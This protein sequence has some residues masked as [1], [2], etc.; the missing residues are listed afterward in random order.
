M[1]IDL[2]KYSES[3]L[4]AM[5]DSTPDNSPLYVEI[6][7]ELDRRADSLSRAQARQKTKQEEEKQRVL[8][9]KEVLQQGYGA[10]SID[11]VIA[12]TGEVEFG[13]DYEIKQEN[14]YYVVYSHAARDDQDFRRI[15]SSLEEANKD[16]R[17]LIYNRLYDR[18]VRTGTTSNV[19]QIGE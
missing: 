14:A 15:H 8:A 5:L 6:E 2:F 16:R 3:R 1:S 19:I 4:N 11:Q 9:L 13:S 7:R 12:T 10:N 17:Y 18:Y